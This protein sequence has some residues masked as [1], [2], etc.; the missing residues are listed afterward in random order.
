MKNHTKILFTTLAMWHR[1]VSSLYTLL[2]KKQTDLLKKVMEIN[3]FDSSFYWRAGRVWKNLENN[4]R[5]Y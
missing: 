4:Q 2:S 3:I 5:P 1:I